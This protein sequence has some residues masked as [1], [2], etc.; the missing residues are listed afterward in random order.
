MC[1]FEVLKVSFMMFELLVYFF[2]G[3]WCSTALLV[4]VVCR[5]INMDDGF[6]NDIV[7]KNHCDLLLFS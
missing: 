1:A 5:C 6:V 3:W 7:H 4:S 2:I